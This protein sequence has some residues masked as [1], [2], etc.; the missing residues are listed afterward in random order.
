MSGLQTFILFLAF[1]TLLGAMGPVG[2][3]RASVGPSTTGAIPTIRECYA[4]LCCRRLGLRPCS[5]DTVR[6]SLPYAEITRG[7][8][9]SAGSPNRFYSHL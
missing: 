4:A 3:A 8:R 5:E 7:A 2:A 9:I 6:G 1:I